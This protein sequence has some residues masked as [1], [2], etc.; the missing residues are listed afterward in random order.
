[1][2]IFVELPTK[3]MS[4]AAKV[5]STE[6][7]P[8]DSKKG[9]KKEENNAAASTPK[10]VTEK[11]PVIEYKQVSDSLVGKTASGTI[12]KVIYA[13]AKFGFI[14]LNDGKPLTDNTPRIYYN[15]KNY[16]NLPDFPP[17]VS[18]EVEFQ[19]EK[20]ENG[21]TFAGNIKLTAAG[22]AAA[23]ARKEAFAKQMETETKS[24]ADAQAAKAVKAKEATSGGAAV[25]TKDEGE[26]K[27]KSKK[28]RKK[29]DPATLK[30]VVLKVTCDGKSETKDVTA[31]I[32]VSLGALKVAATTAFGVADSYKI[33]AANGE[34]L[35]RAIFKGYNDGDKIHL[36][37]E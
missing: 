8:R 17:K 14:Y 12:E 36:K 5:E 10:E 11:K 33:Y 26:K 4:A 7:K 19:V 23:T 27:K 22:L 2:Q 25:A 32:G 9:G 21:R 20:D 18:Y 13:K 34:L 15:F 28:P 24:K 6:K 1:L 37:A 35:S 16:T 3:Q 29:V 30:S 31:T